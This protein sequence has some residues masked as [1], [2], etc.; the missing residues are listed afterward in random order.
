M[1]NRRI[2]LAFSGP[3]GVEQKQLWMKCQVYFPNDYP[4]NATPIFRFDRTAEIGDER[5]EDLV[6]KLES[7]MVAYEQQQLN[8]L[9]ACIRI[10]LGERTVEESLQMLRFRRSIDLE[11]LQ[12]SAQSSSDEDEDDI[13]MPGL[14]VSQETLA[15]INSQYNVP[16]PKA[17]GAL[18]ANDGRLICFFPHKEEKAPSLLDTFSLRPSG[19]SARSHRT[20][21]EGFGYLN[22]KMGHGGLRRFRRAPV[23]NDSDSSEYSYSSSSDSSSSSLEGFTMT[24]QLFMPSVGLGSTRPDS[25]NEI[26]MNESQWSSGD[27]RPEKASIFNYVSLHDCQELLPSKSDLA[28]GYVMSEDRHGCCAHDAQ[29]AREAN[30]HDPAD[31]W[32]FVDLIACGQIPGNLNCDLSQGQSILTLARRAVRP[33]KSRDSAIDLSYDSTPEAQ[34]PDHGGSVGWGQHPFGR[35]WL[36]EEL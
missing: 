18:W 35:Q 19:R 20:I 30:F 13:R 27:T 29:V 11:Q 3:W 33:L 28:R 6:N 34:V 36:V 1:L 32:C 5:M 22:Q 16:L 17:C 12:S 9:E 23:S 10:L 14:D 7:L 24:N 8:S 25:Q 4:N 21:F 26:P 15:D 2:L 31:I